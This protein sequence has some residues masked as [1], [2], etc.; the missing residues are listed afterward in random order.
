MPNCAEHTIHCWNLYGVGG[1]DIHQWMDEPSSLLG[2]HHRKHRHDP[3]MKIPQ[4]FINKYGEE[5]ARNIV[6]DH[7]YLDYELK[8]TKLRKRVEA[9][10]R[11]QEI[12]FPI[13]LLFNESPYEPYTE[14]W[15]DWKERKE[16]N[17]MIDVVIQ[18][19]HDAAKKRQKDIGMNFEKIRGRK[20]RELCQD[21]IRSEIKKIVNSKKYVGL[22][23]GWFSFDYYGNVARIELQYLDP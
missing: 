15:W 20:A 9:L 14:K 1:A 2:S 6:L 12:Q 13:D 11:A 19:I 5:L 3:Q 18:K 23:Y 7:L 22:Y 21:I 10:E 8:D 16:R 4:K 17:E